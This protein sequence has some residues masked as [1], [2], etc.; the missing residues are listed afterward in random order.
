M[1]DLICDTSPIQYLHQLELLHILPALG[2]RV[3]VPPAVVDEIAAG[4]SL[5]VDLPDLGHLDDLRAFVQAIDALLLG[6]FAVSNN[7]GA[8]VGC[9][10]GW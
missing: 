10:N 1:P 9:A 2:D 6:A 8:R 7:K 3:L 4:R 5:G